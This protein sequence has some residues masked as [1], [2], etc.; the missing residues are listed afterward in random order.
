MRHLT[1]RSAC[2]WHGR[3]AAGMHR[4]RPALADAARR[5]AFCDLQRAPGVSSQRSCGCTAQA[6]TSHAA[7]PAHRFPRR[8][9]WSLR[10]CLPF[11][12]LVKA[13]RSL[14]CQHL[15]LAAANMPLFLLTGERCKPADG[16]VTQRGVCDERRHECAADRPGALSSSVLSLTSASCPTWH[17]WLIYEDRRASCGW[18]R[19]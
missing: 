16:R 9:A 1:D 5:H 17:P 18:T 13:L 4:L 8:P 6:C 10:R 15:E 7:S 11:V 14:H 12:R 2:L 19:S 3:P